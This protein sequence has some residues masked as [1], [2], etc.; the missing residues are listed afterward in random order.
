MFSDVVC[1][2]PPT[3]VCLYGF[4]IRLDY[5]HTFASYSDRIIYN[6][7]L[8]FD[9]RLEELWLD[10]RLR[11]STTR[12]GHWKI[13]ETRTLC[14]SSWLETR[15]I[16]TRS[17]HWSSAPDYRK[18]KLLMRIKL[19]TFILLKIHQQN[20]MKQI[21]T[22]RRC[23]LVTGMLLNFIISFSNRG[24]I[25]FSNATLIKDLTNFSGLRFSVFKSF[26]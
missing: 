10:S 21:T 4:Y 6:L 23:L 15:R 16:V 13:L 26:L 18:G 8:G 17:Q 3:L 25:N 19:P 2:W 5:T 9:L 11:C 12:L 20:L 14:D 22:R 24:W 1:F 7:R